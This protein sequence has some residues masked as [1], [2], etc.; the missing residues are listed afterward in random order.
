VGRRGPKPRDKY[1][2]KSQV[3]TTR[4]EHDLRSELEAAS[5][6]KGHS[7]SQEIGNRLR[8]SFIEDDKIEYAFGNLRNY[9]LAQIVF[10]ILQTASNPEKPDVDWLHDPYAFDLACQTLSSFLATMRPSGEGKL[11]NA[12]LEI[13]H[14]WDPIIAAQNMV[15]EIQGADP[16]LDL[17]KSSDRM[18]RMGAFKKELGEL[19]DRRAPRRK[20][21]LIQSQPYPEAPKSIKR[22]KAKTGQRRKP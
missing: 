19:L 10:L 11:S 20:P 18:L 21:R 15:M 3:L 16:T 5:K 4:I 9:R 13:G 6:K 12:S 2:K 22:G 8:R 14:G 17:R 1:S 7:L